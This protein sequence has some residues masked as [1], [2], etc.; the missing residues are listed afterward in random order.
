MFPEA[1]ALCAAQILSLKDHVIW[2]K[3]RAKQLNTWIGLKEAD[4]K[5]RDDK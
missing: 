2:S 1:A 5:S 3:V 4:K